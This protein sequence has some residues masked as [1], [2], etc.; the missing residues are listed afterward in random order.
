L[1]VVTPQNNTPTR[2][3][4]R[5]NR[6]IATDKKNTVDELAMNPMY[7]GEQS[8]E[9]TLSTLAHEMVHQ[10]QQLYGKPSHLYCA[11]QF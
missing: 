7:F 1:I 6:F 8:I 9:K 5:A 3:Y 2:G 4:Y 11:I 10:H